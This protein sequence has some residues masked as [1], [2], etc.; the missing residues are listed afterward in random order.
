M[1]ES[2]LVV[3]EREEKL[4]REAMPSF[5]NCAFSRLHGFWDGDRCVGGIYLLADYPYDS[6]V[7]LDT[8]KPSLLPAIAKCAND[9]LEV[10]GQLIATIS[11]TNLKAIGFV[12]SLGFVELYVK[13]GMSHNQLVRENWA[14]KDK[15]PLR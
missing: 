15:Y 9:L 13:E 11:E 12:R 7:E 6:G 1:I 10:N 14:Y 4:V 5:K 2:H 3:D 8:Y